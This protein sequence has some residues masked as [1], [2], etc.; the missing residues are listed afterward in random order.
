M[1]MHLVPS[2][3]HEFER[4]IGFETAL[5]HFHGALRRAAQS[6]QP[7]R[8]YGMLQVTCSDEFQGEIRASFD[9]N[10]ARP[11]MSGA[12][13]G[14][15]HTFALANMGGRLEAGALALAQNH[16]QSNDPRAPARLLLVEITAHVGV[17]QTSAGKQWGYVDRFGTT[18]ECC[19]ALSTLIANPTTTAA[20]RHP[21]FDQLSRFFGPERLSAL[22]ADESP[23]RMLTAAIIHAV[24]QAE[25][26]VTDLLREPPATA[27]HVLIAPL[28]VI[29]QH[30]LEQTIP[31][32]MHHLSADGREIALV[33]GR[34][35]RSTPAALRIGTDAGRVHVTSDEGLESARERRAIVAHPHF[36]EQLRVLSTADDEH[37]REKAR[38][39]QHT[40]E[41][42]EAHVERMKK[43][44]QAWRAYARPMLRG[45]IQGLSVVAPEVG[46]AA[47]LFEFGRDAAHAQHLKRLLERGP[48]SEE[49]R[50]VLHD[51]E[52]E[53]QQL[54]HR[55]AQD[56][57]EILMQESKALVGGAKD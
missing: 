6:I 12:I 44:P 55:E 10:V 13:D 32:G 47:L 25:S 9:R 42:T 46:V 34:S 40:L 20:V 21:W 19:G 28:V 38:R 45:L 37:G 26:A 50:K 5:D 33:H 24:L 15:R 52:A 17:R 1:E 2:A 49:A 35:L 22:R 56:V 8:G 29:N 57:L 51:L 39:V 48:S 4:L 3:M 30:G 18:S 36:T 27:T 53:I 31:V 43:H 14:N 11:L 16:F 7:V 54:G 41:R 23:T